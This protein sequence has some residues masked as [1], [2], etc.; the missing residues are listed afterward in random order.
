MWRERCVCTLQSRVIWPRWP[1]P[2][3]WIASPRIASPHAYLGWHRCYLHLAS[4]PWVAPITRLPILTCCH[5]DNRSH[6]QDRLGRRKG[7]ERKTNRGEK[8]SEAEL[9]RTSTALLWQGEGQGPGFEGRKRVLAV[10]AA[11]AVPAASVSC[12]G[13]YRGIALS[14]WK[15]YYNKCA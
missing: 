15:R 9:R 13:F 4:L 10:W 12:A 7:A 1:Q 14:H 8:G 6:D 5:V 2:S 3:P 11:F